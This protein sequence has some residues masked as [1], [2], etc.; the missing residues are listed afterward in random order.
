MADWND[1]MAD[2]VS[3]SRELEPM[4]AEW[5]ALMKPRTVDQKD[6]LHLAFTMGSIAAISIAL[7]RT[8]PTMW[9]DAMREQRIA[10]Q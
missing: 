6:A 1:P 3:V 5:I 8:R 7:K 2:D 9:Q 10:R 4:W